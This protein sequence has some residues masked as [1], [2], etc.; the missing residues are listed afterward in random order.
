MAVQPTK[1]NIL[2]DTSVRSLAIVAGEQW[3]GRPISE[4]EA[5]L[6]NFWKNGGE[7]GRLATVKYQVTGYKKEDMELERAAIAAI[8]ANSLIGACQL[9]E[10]KLIQYEM[11]TQP[12][13]RYQAQSAGLNLFDGCT[14]GLL[15]SPID[16]RIAELEALS[17]F[18]GSKVADFSKDQIQRLIANIRSDYFVNLKKAIPGKSEDCFN[19]FAAYASSSS[20]FMTLDGPLLNNFQ[21]IQKN[22]KLHWLRVKIA[23][24]STIANELGLNIRDIDTVIKANTTWHYEA[25]QMTRPKSRWRTK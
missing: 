23:R 13:P 14:F 6:Q 11:S 4:T 16:G 10:T 18:G 5:D 15:E 24:P 7:G 20:Y 21:Q 1:S 25:G 17:L 12:R 3:V 2:V 9:A 8:A 22:Q 19:I